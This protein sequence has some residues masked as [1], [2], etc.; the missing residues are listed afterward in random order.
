MIS[1]K[2]DGSYSKVGWPGKASL[3]EWF[4]SKCLK[5]EKKRPKCLLAGRD[6]QAEVMASAEF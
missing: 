2:G 1:G 6:F 4:W 3:S 5:E